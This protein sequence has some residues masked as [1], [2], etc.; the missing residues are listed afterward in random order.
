MSEHAALAGWI[1]ELAGE[2]V[3]S[4]VGDMIAEEWMKD[5]QRIRELEEWQR[6]MVEKV[7]EKSLDGYHELG[8][9]AADAENRLDESLRRVRELEEAVRDLLVTDKPA[10]WRLHL[11]ESRYEEIKA[12]EPP[13]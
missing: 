12:L 7:A 3:E 5:R 6:Q 4:W 9:R 10:A 2:Y 11:G 1:R 13:R 8:R